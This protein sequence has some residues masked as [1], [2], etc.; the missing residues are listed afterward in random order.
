MDNTEINNKTF[1]E[2]Q[3]ELSL[4]VNN[5]FIFRED[6]IRAYNDVTFSESNWSSKNMR[7]IYF[8]DCK[9]LN[10]DFKSTGF[11][12]SI[13]KNCLFDKGILDYA[14]FDECQFVN[15]KFIQQEL[16]ATSFCKS[17]F[18]DSTF[19]NSKLNACF[20]TNGIFEGGSFS[21]CVITDIIWENAYFKKWTFN[22]TTLQ[23]LNFEFTSFESIHFIETSIPF[24]SLPFVFGGIQYILNTQDEV[25]IK[26]I[27]PNYPQNKLPKCEYINLIPNILYFYQRTNNYFPVANILLG[28]GDIQAGI[29]AIKNGIKFWFSLRNYKIMTYFCKLAD[30]YDFSIENRKIIYNEI[31]KCNIQILKNESWKEQKHWGMFQF[32]MREYLLNSKNMPYVTVQFQTNIDKHNFN[33]LC[34]FMETVENYIMEEGLFYYLELR[35]NSPFELLYTVLSDEQNLFNF[36]VGLISILGVCN[37]LYTNHLANK[38]SKKISKK[39]QEQINQTIVKNITNIQYNFYNCNINNDI[40]HF[41]AQSIGWEKPE[42]SGSSQ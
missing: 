40:D 10:V 6:Q 19:Y 15:C 41:T 39:A 33:A 3:N 17:E 37:Q 16:N 20:F 13:F 11:T 4:H 25:W 9:F 14:I 23:K 1:K 32:Q 7:R 18:Y 38:Q 28:A 2:I 26:T 24:P 21:D 29:E 27:H 36:I 5:K 8:L 34:Q 22:K 30:I 35:H 42:V 31:E 12:G